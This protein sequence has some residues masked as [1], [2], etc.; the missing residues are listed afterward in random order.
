M[1]LLPDAAAQ[2]VSFSAASIP[3][4]HR[5]ECLREFH[6]RIRMRMR[7]DPHPGHALRYDVRTLMLPDMT[8][9]VASASP[10]G[11]A[12]TS[13][14][15][16]DGN[17]DIMISWNR[18]GYHLALPGKGDYQTRPGH[19]VLLSLDRRLAA[20]TN[21]S[22]WALVLQVKRSLLAPLVGNIDDLEPDIIGRAQ[23]AHGLL[24]QYLRALTH[25]RTPSALAP[26]A[27]RH[28]VDL[29]AAAL[30]AGYGDAPT[31]GVRAA[32]LAAIKHHI[33][34]NLA[35]P[36]LS[37]EQVARKFAISARYVRQL[38]AE[39]G[40]SFSDY[41]TDRRLAHIHGCLSDPRQV[42][43]PIGDIAFEA[44]FI[45]PSTFY[46]QFRRRYRMTPSDVRRH[47]IG[48]P[49]GP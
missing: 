49:S 33:M 17:D 47:A 27:S 9:A 1:S 25:A 22:R 48:A 35:D 2:I 11:W 43:R 38:F 20:T 15:L 13:E 36:A 21:D 4:R 14:L 6:G 40:T 44:G 10:V 23:P 41:V 32:R 31:P 37:A 5:D 24:F 39:Q 7:I 12:R 30:G 42:L 34:A 29:L 28:I 26:M 45:E 46:R 18:G 19:A 16:A 8:C 3:E